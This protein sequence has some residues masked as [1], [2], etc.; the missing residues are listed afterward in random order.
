LIHNREL[1]RELNP[2]ELRTVELIA[3]GLGNRD[4]GIQMGFS[5]HSVRQ[6]IHRIFDKLGF[7]HRTELALWYVK[8]KNE[9]AL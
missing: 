2:R 1:C 8:K 3:D 5:T 9:G 6:R 7:D 4:I